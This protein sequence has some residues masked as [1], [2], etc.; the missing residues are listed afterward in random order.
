MNKVTA[1]YLFALMWNRLDAD[2]FEPFVSEDIVY[3]SQHVM[4]PMMGKPSVMEYLSE[5]VRTIRQSG[6]EATVFA[7]LGVNAQG[8]FVIL[9]QG[10]SEKFHAKIHIQCSDG[11]IKRLSERGIAQSPPDVRTVGIVPR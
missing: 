5:R 11:L 6:T 7:E 8:P 2:V 4:E 1:A 3:E 9:T 10:N